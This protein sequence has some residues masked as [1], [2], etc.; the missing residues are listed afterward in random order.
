MPIKQSYIS[1]SHLKC[2]RRKEIKCVTTIFSSEKPLQTH[3][4]YS[5]AHFNVCALFLCPPAVRQQCPK[6]E[7]SYDTGQ[8]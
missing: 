5:S 1:Y 7:A 6:V 3:K 8:L 2:S 4:L